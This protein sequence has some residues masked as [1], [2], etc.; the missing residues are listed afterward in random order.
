M[1]RFAR[2]DAP[3]AALLLSDARQKLRPNRESPAVAPYLASWELEARQ[4]GDVEVAIAVRG[5]KVRQRAVFCE[6][7]ER[8]FGQA[9]A[10][11]GGAIVS[12]EVDH[13]PQR[14]ELPELVHGWL[15]RIARWLSGGRGL[16]REATAMGPIPAYLCLAILF[17]IVSQRLAGFR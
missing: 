12:V 1:V 16:T 15:D 17:A 3:P 10:A 8:R 2:L 7:G 5:E 6:P 4:P 9:R 13:P 14:V 11:Y